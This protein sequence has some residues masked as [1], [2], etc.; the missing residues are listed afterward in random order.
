MDPERWREMGVDQEFHSMQMRILNA[1][2]RMGVE[3]TCTC[4][5]YH[6]VNVP[7]PGEHV[8]WAES[9]AVNYINSVVGAR[10][11]REGG[12]SALAAAIAGRTPEW[13]LHIKENRRP[14]VLVDVEGTVRDWYTLGYILGKVCISRIPYIRGVRPDRDGMKAISAALATSGGVPMFHVEGVTPEAGWASEYLDSCERHTVTAEDIEE[15]RKDMNTTGERPELIALGCPHL[16]RDEVAHIAALLRDR[17]PAEGR[18]EV[19]FCTSR[20]VRKDTAEEVEVL[21]RFGRVLVDTCMVVA[22]VENRFKVT[23]TNSAK[24]AHYMVMKKF[25]GQR[26]VYM[27]LEDL[28]RWCYED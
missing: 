3:V 21:E 11:N 10:T 25:G 19:W 2:R 22:P 7:S 17:K 12:P 20:E 15:T 8:A 5:P 6:G 18:P 26:M 9:S 23:G 14:E 28:L 1:Y 27:P 13:G 16:S 24:A 4:A